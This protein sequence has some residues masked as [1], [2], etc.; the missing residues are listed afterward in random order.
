MRGAKS[1]DTGSVFFLRAGRGGGQDG[2]LG[3]PRGRAGTHHPDPGAAAEEQPGAS[4]LQKNKHAL[5]GAGQGL[6]R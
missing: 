4:D 6:T 3:G 2:P 1:N 5:L